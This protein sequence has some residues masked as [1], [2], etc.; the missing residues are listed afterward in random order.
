MPMARAGFFTIDST[1]GRTFP[2]L[3]KLLISQNSA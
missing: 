3:D 2:K 1:F